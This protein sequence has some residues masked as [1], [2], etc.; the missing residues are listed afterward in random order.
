MTNGLPYGMK[1]SC[2]I[3]YNFVDGMKLTQLIYI[4]GANLALSQKKRTSF[5]EPERAGMSLDF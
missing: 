3:A 4:I 1:G 5:V 2:D